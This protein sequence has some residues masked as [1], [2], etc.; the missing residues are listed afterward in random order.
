MRRALIGV[1]VG[2]L[3]GFLAAGW[4]QRQ[5][6]AERDRVPKSD[7]VAFDYLG[8]RITIVR[9]TWAK[10]SDRTSAVYPFVEPDRLPVET[11]EITC[12]KNELICNEVVARVGS[13][14]VL[15]IRHGEDSPIKSW[16]SKSIVTEVNGPIP[17][18]AKIVT[19]YELL[20]TAEENPVGGAEVEAVQYVQRKTPEELAKYPTIMTENC[21]S[22]P[23]QQEFVL[24][25]GKYALA[26]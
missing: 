18:C 12:Y 7:F 13:D 8:D 9:G 22:Y 3:V 10:S 17:I 20:K 25:G 15:R 1:I 21:G 23:Q 14:G 2:L 16:D 26:H 5:M 11:S 4:W 24:S 6:S 19:R